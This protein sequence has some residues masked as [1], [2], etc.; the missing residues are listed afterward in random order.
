MNIVGTELNDSKRLRKFTP[1]IAILLTMPNWVLICKNIKTWVDGNHFRPLGDGLYI[2]SGAHLALTGQVDTVFDPLKFAHWF[3][4]N[5]GGDLHVWG[6]PPS[7]LLFALPFGFLSPL[8]TVI[9]FDF[10]SILC[11]ALALRV[12]G[13]EWKICLAV[14]FCPAALMNFNISQNGALIASL[15][16]SGLWLADRSPW[17]AGI[18]IGLVTIKPQLGIL[19][20]IYLLAQ[21]NWRSITSASMTFITLVL[22]SGWMFRP[23]SWYMFADKVLPF[24]RYFLVQLTREYHLGPRAMIMSVFSLSRQAGLDATGSMTLQMITMIC[25]IGVTW[26]IGRSNRLT[27][28]YKLA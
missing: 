5:F 26:K 25:V 11:L 13:F 10:I 8:G 17:L 1:A 23:Q 20:P 9:C 7:Y 27:T 12:S 6:Y 3:A 14:L 15:L 19:V 16:I 28:Q 18:L 2:W 22:V 4:S 24:M 21:G